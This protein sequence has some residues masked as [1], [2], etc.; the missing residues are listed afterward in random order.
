MTKWKK[1]LRIKIL[2]IGS[3]KLKMYIY[4]YL[5]NIKSIER[6]FSSEGK[7]DSK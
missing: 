5:G 1:Y 2:E 7:G 3:C 6:S 4:L